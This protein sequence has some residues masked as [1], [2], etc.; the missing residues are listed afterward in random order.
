MCQQMT[1]LASGMGLPPTGEGKDGGE[2]SFQDMIEKVNEKVES[3]KETPE[4]PVEKQ[5]T[6]EQEKAPASPKEEEELKAENLTVNPNAAGLVDLFRPEITPVAEET[7]AA[8]VLVEAVVETAEEPEAAVE[9][10]VMDAG[11]E[12]AETVELPEEPQ[13]G[14][15]ETLEKAPQQQA[16]AP[17]EQKAEVE[18]KQTVETEEVREELPEVKTEVRVQED[19]DEPKAEAAEVEEPLFHDVKAAPVKVGESY[20][21]VDTQEPDMDEKLADAI[22]QAAQNG[23]ER[24]EIRLTPQNLG[25]LTIEMAKDASGALQVVIHASSSKAAGLLHQHLDGLH[26]A[27][28]SYSQEP[29]QIEVHRGEESQQQNLHQQADP[30]GRGRQQQNQQQ[31]REEHDSGDFLQKLRLGLVGASENL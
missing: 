18:T 25:A 15:Q 20:E 8:P 13:A 22:R 14:F 29:V 10:P 23:S 12:T 6:A 7:A 5:E 2:A 19:G 21:T 1:L 26:A 31:E 11:A 9:L 30:D 3:G 16:E 17:V 24:V 27:L 4:K 28:Q